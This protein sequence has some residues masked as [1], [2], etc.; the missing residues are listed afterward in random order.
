MYPC[1]AQK[2][3]CAGARMRLLPEKMRLQNDFSIV[4]AS[5]FRED[6]RRQLRD[7]AYAFAMYRERFLMTDR[8]P[9]NQKRFKLTYTDCIGEGRE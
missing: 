5:L 6:A 3:N 2:N 7:H 1:R 4:S 9:E 8:L